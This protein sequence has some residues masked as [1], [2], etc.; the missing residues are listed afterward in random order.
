MMGKTYLKSILKLAVALVAIGGLSN[1]WAAGCTQAPPG[2]KTVALV[3][4]TSGCAALSN[5]GSTNS[6]TGCRM[7]PASGITS[8][9]VAGKFRATSAM[10]PDGSVYWA[11][12]P[13][14]TQYTT[15]ADAVV[16]GGGNGGSNCGYFYKDDA[17]TGNQL[18][19]LKSNGSYQNVTYVDVCTNGTNETPV[20][21]RQLP[22]C[23]ADVQTAL[24]DGTIP[25]DFAIVGT[26]HNADDT[27]F[28][29]RSGA[30][31]KEC[32]NEERQGQGP[33]PSGLPLCSEGPHGDGTDLNFK[34]GLSF[35]MIKTGDHSS[36]YVCLP[37]TYTFAGGSSC[38]WV[39]Y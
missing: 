9:T 2:A 26:V 37:P 4:G 36:V 24:N 39:Y 1:A 20:V 3:D 19:Y 10:N 31:V 6:W 21:T 28:C 30:T 32:I 12:D 15:K 16:V 23:P 35:S 34:R 22:V 7:D 14:Y 5:G 25:G 18:G 29:I 33:D 27:T 38:G 11:L 17:A 13:T 8:C